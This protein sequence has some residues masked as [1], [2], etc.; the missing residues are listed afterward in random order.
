MHQ[1][2]GFASKVQQHP[3]PGNGNTPQT[4]APL[5]STLTRLRAG[6]GLG[7]GLRGGRPD[8]KRTTGG[9]TGNTNPEPIHD[10]ALA[11][12]PPPPPPTDHNHE[13]TG[14]RNI[15]SLLQDTP[16]TRSTATVLIMTTSTWRQPTCSRRYRS[17]VN[18]NWSDS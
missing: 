2:Q 16:R 3:P 17:S 11:L 12:L 13:G 18:A 1:Q 8:R 14:L 6:R 15:K 5:A 10:P 7:L 9:E 4:R